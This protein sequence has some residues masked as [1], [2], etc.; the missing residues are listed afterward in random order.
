MTFL[1]WM[2]VILFT[3]SNLYQR[4]VTVVEPSL[5]TA[6]PH[7]FI[8]LLVVFCAAI[9]SQADSINPLTRLPLAVGFGIIFG[10]NLTGIQKGL[11]VHRRHKFYESISQ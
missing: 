9:M 11:K 8:C 7:L 2:L 10:D 6:L 3:V 5:R 4:V 1:L